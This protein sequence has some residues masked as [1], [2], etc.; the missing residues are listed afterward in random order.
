VLLAAPPVVFVPAP[1]W[2]GLRAGSCVALMWLVPLLC[3]SSLAMW[4]PEKT[5]PTVS[6]SSREPPGSRDGISLS[7]RHQE[8]AGC[9]PML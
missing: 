3:G 5:E 8:A 7:G 2:I 6:G 4:R 1:G 9:E